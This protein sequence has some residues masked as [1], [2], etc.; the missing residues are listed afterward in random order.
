MTFSTNNGFIQNHM[1]DNQQSPCLCESVAGRRP[2][3]LHL[4]SVAGRKA[5][6]QGSGFR[7]W[8]LGSVWGLGWKWFWMNVFLN[9]SVFG[10]VFFSHLDESVPNLYV[11]HRRVSGCRVW[12]FRCWV[13]V[14]LCPKCQRRWGPK[15]PKPPK[16]ENTQTPEHPNTQT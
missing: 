11:K 2:A 6:V 8:G 4:R 13:K 15:P 10:W 3:T 12:V 14:W 16:P 9:E 7:V 5:G 1:W